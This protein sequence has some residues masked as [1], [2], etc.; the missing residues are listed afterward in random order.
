MTPSAP[1]NTGAEP[2]P[3]PAYSWYALGVLVLVYFVNFVDRQILSILAND[4]KADLGLSDADL[5]F[6]YG[7]AFAI[8][9]ALFGI[10]LGR[11]ADRWHRVRLMAIG[12]G[13]WSAMTALSG[14]ARGAGVLTVARIGVGVGEATSSP[15]AYSL[16]GDWFPQRLRATALAIYSSGIYLGIGFSLVVGGLTVERWNA[17][18]PG[19]GPLGLAG[20]QAAFL[21]VGL[22]GLLLGLWVLTLREPH[23]PCT[24]EGEGPFADFGKSMLNLVPPLTIIG[25][26][27]RGPRALALNLIGAAGCA[28]GAWLLIMLTGNIQQWAMVA[29]AY[30]AIF[31]W[32]CSLQAGDRATFARTWGSPAFLCI[33]I[34]YGLMCIIAYTVTYWAA[35][36]AERNFAVSKTELG[37]WL[38]APQAVAGFAGVVIGGRIADWLQ[39]RRAD[40]RILMVLFGLLAPLPLIALAYTTRNAGL[41]FILS[42]AIQLVM[43]TALGSAAAAS[44]ALVE[45][46][47]RGVATAIFFLG[48]TLIGLALGP[49]LAGFVS[50]GTGDNLGLGVMST[51]LAAIPASALLVGAARLVRQART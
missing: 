15:A 43:T 38:G 39:E 21:I 17:A 31:S 16:I 8:F 3:V 32:A 9:F 41:F 2:Q 26:A 22:P 33:V 46:H 24:V 23:R 20:W 1:D 29:L 6:L 13:L 51:M 5:G 34:G 50:A 40:G 11:L 19:G 30:Y 7:T 18:F 25:A 45:P 48:T 27:V 28:V 47:M 36:F 12:L 44:Q 10:P 35:P 49:F 14:L 37:L 42:F 4:I